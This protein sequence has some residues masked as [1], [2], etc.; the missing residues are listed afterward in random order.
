MNELFAETPETVTAFRDWARRAVAAI[1]PLI[2]ADVMADFDAETHADLARLVRLAKAH[3]YRLGLFGL[4]NR[5]PEPRFKTVLDA[6]LRLQTCARH[7]S[8]GRKSNGRGR[9]T[10]PQVAE[11]YG[12]SP[13]TVRGW[14]ERGELRAVNIAR[15][16]SKR[17]RY[18]IEPDALDEFDRKKVPNVAPP[19]PKRRRVKMP[20]LLVTKF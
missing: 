15:P 12:A 1:E 4:A 8:G 7:K 5:L 14:I 11:R 3:A 19:T 13:D 18:R 20:K 10:P 9:L 2:A 6:L 16:G 17:A